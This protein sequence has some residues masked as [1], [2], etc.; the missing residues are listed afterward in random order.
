MRII[1]LTEET[2]ETLY[3]L[4]RSDLI[5]GVSEYAVRPP[6]AKQHPVVTQFIRSD[7]DKIVELKPD[8]V[9]GFSDLQR[10]IAADLIGKGLNVLVTNQR[11]LNEIL[12]TI[13]LLGKIIGED[14]KARILVENFRNKIELYRNKQLKRKP[15][16]YFEEWDHPRYSC[17]QWVSEL[18]EICGGEN[19]FRHKTGKSAREREVTDE[20]IISLNPD[21]IFGCWCGKPVKTESFQKRYPSTSAVKNNFIWELPPSVFLQP[22]PALFVDG[23]DQMFEKI[24]RVAKLDV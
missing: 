17:I 14:L 10:D 11:S 5:V 22:G 3:L 9:I 8:L 23:L 15:K 20:E 1:C 12:E 21:I 19:I 7:I 16:I 24:E 18:I 13:L 4:G 2:V 6:E